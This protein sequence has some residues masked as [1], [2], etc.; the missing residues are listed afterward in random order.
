MFT[1]TMFI[2][3]IG[4]FCVLTNEIYHSYRDWGE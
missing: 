1:T 4:A 3:S 2:L